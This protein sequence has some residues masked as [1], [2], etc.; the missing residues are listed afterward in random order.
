MP[1]SSERGRPVPHGSEIPAVPLD[2]Y[3]MD[4]G[5]AARA[6]P[7]V[8]LPYALAATFLE[9]APVQTQTLIQNDTGTAIGT[10]GSEPAAETD[11]ITAVPAQSRAAHH[12]EAAPDG[13]PDLDEP[14]AAAVEALETAEPPEPVELPR[15]RPD[16]S[17]PSSDLFRQYLREI[18]RIPLLTAVE[19]VE[20]ARRVEA[21]LFAEERLGNAPD[22]DTRLTL[23]LDRLVVMGRMAKRRLIEANLRL[24][25]S[26]A[27]R[28]VGR[29]LTMLDL[30]QEGNLGLIRAVEKFDYARGYKFSTY[31]TWWIRQA[32]SR[33]LADQARTI[34]VPVHVVELINR[35]VRVQRR[36]LQERGYEPTPE[37]VAA[38]LDLAPERVSEVLRLAQEPVSLHAPVGEED[39]V[40]LGDLIED[41]DATSP[42]ESAAFLLLREHLEAV[43]STLGERERKVVQLRYGLADGRPRTLEEIG[44]IF[45]VTR[46]RI[47][48][49]ESKTLNKLRDHAFADQLRGYL[50]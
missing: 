31:A 21:G 17:G 10:D 50:D 48:Q 15:A 36:M 37:E 18:G 49:I 35:V 1:E 11:V 2:E 29:G 25:V 47:R 20:L 27:K 7:D 43:L 26:V 4:G 41:G 8:P 42:V 30:V 38:H 5:E 3:G 14:P 45:G 23:D 32:M 19:E 28:Y 12:P 44:R 46:E 33:A 9:V 13:P 6:I 39:D 22:L 24:V 40:A 16:T 34:R